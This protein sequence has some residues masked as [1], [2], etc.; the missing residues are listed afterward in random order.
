MHR[1]LWL[2][3][4]LLV[5]LFQLFI[6]DEED[7]VPRAHAYPG[8][9]EAF[10]QRPEPFTAHRSHGTI[11]APGVVECWCASSSRASATGCCCCRCHAG[12]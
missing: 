3:R 8:R 4:A 5:E 6:G 7:D 9:D 2:L 11:Q 1:L 10:V 12:L